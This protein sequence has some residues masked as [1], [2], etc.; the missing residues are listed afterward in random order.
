M[1]LLPLL[2]LLLFAS[3]VSAQ[4]PAITSFAPTQ[5]AVG[6]MVTINGTNFSSTAANNIVYFGATR[7][8]VLTATSTQLSVSV[9]AGATY[10]PISVLVGG[11]IAYAN[12]P[13]S[14][15]FDGTTNVNMNSFASKIDFTA[16]VGITSVFVSDI[17]GDGKPDLVVPNLDDFTVSVLRNTSTVSGTTTFASKVDLTTAGNPSHVT[18]GDLDGDGK[19]DLAIGCSAAN[20]ISVLRNTSTVGNVSF[21]TK[22]DFSAGGILRAITTADLTSDGKTDLLFANANNVGV[23]LNTSSPGTISFATK[24]D[25]AVGTGSAPFFIGARDLDNDGKV[26][27]VTANYSNSKFSVFRNTTTAGVLSFASRLDFTAG[28]SPVSIAIGD[29]DG[30]DKPDLAVANLGDSN[31]SLYRNTST[32]GTI[33]FAT[34]VDLTLS[35][36]PFSVAVANIDGDAALD[37]VCVASSV[38]QVSVFRNTSTVGSFSFDAKV[39][40]ATGSSPRTL[41]IA[42]VDQNSKADLIVANSTSGTI[43]VLANRIKSNQTITFGSLATRIYGDAPLNLSATASSALSVSYTSSNTSVATINGNTLTITGAGTSTITASQSGNNDFNSANTVQQT[44]TVN[45]ASQSITFAALA[46]KTYG[47]TPYSI[48]ATSS[49]GLPL[50]FVSSNTDVAAVSGSTLTIVGTGTA[51]ITASQPGDVNYLP[52]GNVQQVLTVNKASQ[53]ISFGTIAN[54]T[55]GDSDFELTPTSTSQLPVSL[56]SSDPAV[57]TISGST[58]TIIGAGTTTFTASQTGNNNYH[59]AAD[60]QQV[61]TVNKAN[62]TIMFTSLTT[63]TVGDAPFMLEAS[64]TSGLPVLYSSSNTAV[65]TISGSTVT[66]TN[67]GSTVISASQP[68][69]ANYNAAPPVERTL[70]VKQNQTISFPTIADKTLGDAAFTLN[71]TSTASLPISYSSA[72]NKITIEGTQVTLVSAG[73]VNIT[74][75]QGGNDA[76]NPAVPVA[77]SFCIKP[78][79]PTITLSGVNMAVA[80]LAS[81]AATG[82]QWYRNGVLIPGATNSTFEI[83]QAG[84]YKV[85]VQIDDCI[86]PFSDEHPIIVTGLEATASDLIKIFPNPVTEELTI[87]LTGFEKGNQVDVT[88]LDLHGRVLEHANGEG[89]GRARLNVHPLAPGKYI[90]RLTQGHTQV[91][92]VFIKK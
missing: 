59:P 91:V 47:E 46:P 10:Q 79:K 2:S 66:I 39:D 77:Q 74:A 89:G 13:F 68:G 32:T 8:S 31:L 65:A 21:A 19:P 57:A 17:D 44:L 58:V 15:T 12:K 60:V 48:P 69:N 55:F 50:T 26:D 45:K 64:S 41:F 62:Q 81:S 87:E 14:V 51:V 85:Q 6:S 61:L 49:S 4:V 5:G 71:A 75:T 1:R 24:V 34:K 27:V 83:N 22:Q 86:S 82:N 37:L 54:K 20:T 29:L 42:D 43:S 36:T 7:A 9:P 73:R 18:V 92:K 90:V 72:S 78:A 56:V 30:D 28:D 33:S 76:Y 63:K 25:F 35:G 53:T 3:N 70:I 84:S 40:F 88:I 80:S 67:A 23:M 16:G 38:N 52:A 11:L